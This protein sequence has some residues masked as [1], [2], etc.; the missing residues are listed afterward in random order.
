MFFVFYDCPK[1]S[2]EIA[3]SPSLCLSLVNCTTWRMVKI[4]GNCFFLQKKVIW[5]CCFFLS[6]FCFHTLVPHLRMYSRQPMLIGL[7]QRYWYT[8]IDTPPT[9]NGP[10][11]PSGQLGSTRIACFLKLACLILK[12]VR[13]KMA[14]QGISFIIKASDHQFD[15]PPILSGNSFKSPAFLKILVIVVKMSE[16][17]VFVV[18]EVKCHTAE[19]NQMAFCW[20][21]WIL[22]RLCYLLS[23]KMCAHC[24]FKLYANAF[25]AHHLKW[26]LLFFFVLLFVHVFD[27]GKLYNCPAQVDRV[28]LH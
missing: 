1:E 12:P 7:E 22:T 17:H 9:I 5:K 27:A 24:K 6:L 26:S 28:K 13:I 18:F 21:R 16:I 25:K 4:D 2:T 11:S 23:K 8:D 10:Y 20:K 3:P 19:V 14:A 15:C